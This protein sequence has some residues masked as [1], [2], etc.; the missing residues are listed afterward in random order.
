MRVGRS[1]AVRNVEWLDSG[2][3]LIEHQAKAPHVDG[4]AEVAA[5]HLLWGHV[6]GCSNTAVAPA[7]GTGQAQVDQAGHTVVGDDIA[8]FDVEMQVSAA[9][10]VPQ[11]RAEILAE[12]AQTCG[13]A[14]VGCRCRG[15]SP[16]WRR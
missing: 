12:V 15:C 9:V 14:A 8:G 4:G 5:A 3:S 13:S 16:R 7:G 2:R 11:G 6:A 1:R 10:Q